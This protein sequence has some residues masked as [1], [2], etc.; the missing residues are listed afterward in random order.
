VEVLTTRTARRKLRGH[1]GIAL[2]G[3]PAVGDQLDIDVQDRQRLL[4]SDIARIGLQNRS[5]PLKS[6]IDV[7]RI[8]DA[9]IT[10]SDES[11]PQLTSGVEHH[12]VDRVAV[13]AELHNDCIQRSAVEDNRDECLALPFGQLVLHGRAQRDGQV[14]PFGLVSGIYTEAVRQAVPVAGVEGNA[15]LAPEVPPS[16]ADTSRITNRYAPVVK[17]LSPRT[18]ASLLVIAIVASAAA[19]WARSSGSGPAMPSDGLRRFTSL[20]AMRSSKA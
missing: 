17:R 11:G 1:A 4:A 14:A 18:V 5:S 19:W 15:V 2:L 20:R 8:V 6:P 7:P 9:Q 16:F 10:L 12:L 3:A 13:R